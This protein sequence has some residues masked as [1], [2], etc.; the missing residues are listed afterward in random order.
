MCWAR[1]RRGNFAYCGSEPI[2]KFGSQGLER[3]FGMIVVEVLDRAGRWIYLDSLR[4]LN[5]RSGTQR[6][7]AGPCSVSSGTPALTSF[8]LFHI[9]SNLNSQISN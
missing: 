6:R 2:L 1:G 4:K 8:K 7:E 5:S 3:I 9:Y